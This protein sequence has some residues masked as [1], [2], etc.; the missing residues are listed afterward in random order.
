[1]IDEVDETNDTTISIP[2]EVVYRGI[3]SY[4][5]SCKPETT[6]FPGLSIV[7]NTQ[8]PFRSNITIKL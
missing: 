8:T 4:D 2:T 1:M 3:G 6:Y 7:K 5:L